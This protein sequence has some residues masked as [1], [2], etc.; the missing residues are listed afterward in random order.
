MYWI[1]DLLFKVHSFSLLLLQGR[2]VKITIDLLS[3][4]HVFPLFLFLSCFS[5]S[6]PEAVSLITSV[7]FYLDFPQLGLTN[8]CKPNIRL[9]GC[10]VVC[11]LMINELRWYDN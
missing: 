4:S 7:I 10:A 8:H 2:V 6:N 11:A 9:I 1:K 3:V 5:P